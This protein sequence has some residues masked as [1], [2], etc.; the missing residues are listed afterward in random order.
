MDAILIEQVINNLME[1]AMFHSGNQGVLD[2]IAQT[3][4]NDLSVT[5]KDY[6]NGI[7]PA[8]LNTLF[9]GGGVYAN[10]SGDGHKGM[11]IGLSLCKTIITAH[12]GTISASNHESGAMFTFTLPDWREYQI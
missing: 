8:V 5:I 6:G 2:L 11:G 1:N 12:G 9:D 3:T 7:S 4:E 10:Q